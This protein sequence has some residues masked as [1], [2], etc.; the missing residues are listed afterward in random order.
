MIAQAVIIQQIQASAQAVGLDPAIAVQVARQESGLNQDARGAAGEIGIFQLMPATAADLGVNPYDWIQNIQGGV[1]YLK[2]LL[3]QFQGNLAQALAAYNAGP[4]R[5]GNAVESGS[6]WFAQIPATTQSYVSK[7][8]AALG[9]TTSTPP[10]V[11]GPAT[12]V[13]AA[14]VTQLPG[15]NYVYLAP[16]APVAN[17]NWLPLAAVAA[18]VL[19]LAFQD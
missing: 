2:Q 11:A 16:S 4:G 15:G 10:F 6:G 5:V 12:P 13:T 9:I 14:V 1:R 18:S 19:I 17:T 3:N 8:L 7:I